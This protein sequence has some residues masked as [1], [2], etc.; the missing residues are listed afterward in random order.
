M[1]ESVSVSGLIKTFEGK[2]REMLLILGEFIDN[3]IGS[4]KKDSKS[5][6]DVKIFI[7]WKVQCLLFYW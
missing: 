1:S 5:S 2:E 6:V 3:S 7:F 4:A